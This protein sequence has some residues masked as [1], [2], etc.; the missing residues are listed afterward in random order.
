MM[1]ACFP[2]SW[3][4]SGDKGSGILNLKIGYGEYLDAIAM[5]KAKKAMCPEPLTDYD[6]FI[7]IEHL[8]LGG[9]VVDAQPFLKVFCPHHL[10]HMEFAHDCID[11]GLA[12]PH[13][14]LSDLKMSTPSIESSKQVSISQVRAGR[15]SRYDAATHV[16]DSEV[17]P[18]RVY[19]ITYGEKGAVHRQ[20]SSRPNLP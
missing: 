11:G 17:D 12:M 19:E 16:P 1:S 9:F 13:T 4:Y 2:D 5:I 3:K 18:H 6:E 8:V 20:L 15:R 10:K 14:M 7:C